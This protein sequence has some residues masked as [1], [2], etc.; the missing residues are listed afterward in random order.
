[1]TD[2]SMA[3]RKKMLSETV[4]GMPEYAM[5]KRKMCNQKEYMI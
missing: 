3:K 2:N 5:A 1:M 4:Y